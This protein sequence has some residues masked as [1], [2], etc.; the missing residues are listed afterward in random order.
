MANQ[1][2]NVKT[3]LDIFDQSRSE[4]E[5]FLFEKFASITNFY[6]SSINKNALVSKLYRYK[7][8]LKEKR[9]KSKTEFGNELFHYLYQLPKF[10]KL[11]NVIKSKKDLSYKHGLLKTQLERYKHDTLKP[12]INTK[13]NKVVIQEKQNVQK[14]VSEV[15]SLKLDN[16]KSKLMSRNAKLQKCHSKSKL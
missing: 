3:A 12:K 2:V 14:Y 11:K 1:T 16:M 8:K 7:S 6:A 10:Q 15:E 13:M 4:D 5:D 9:G